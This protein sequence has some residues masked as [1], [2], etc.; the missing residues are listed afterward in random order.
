MTSPAQ[1][2]RGVPVGDAKKND[3][4]NL[5][6]EHAGENWEQMF[7][8]AFCTMLLMILTCR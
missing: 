1:M 4:N 7:D 8:S 3:I 6:L 2:E 5:I